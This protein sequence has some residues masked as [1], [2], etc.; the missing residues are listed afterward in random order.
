MLPAPPPLLPSRL[1]TALHVGRG[2]ERADLQKGFPLLQKPRELTHVTM[3]P[4]GFVGEMVPR[5]HRG[6]GPAGRGG[7]SV[8]SYGDRRGASPGAPRGSG[9]TAQG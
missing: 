2:R 8:Y 5:G 3:G 1:P 9:E 6:R 7:T 4:V